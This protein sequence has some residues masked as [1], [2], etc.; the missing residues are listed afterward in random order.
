MTSI[1]LLMAAL[2]PL[3]RGE[4]FGDIRAGD[5]YVA[6]AKVQITCGAESAEGTTDKSGSFRL[7]V[8]ASG[9]CKFSVTHNKQTATIDVVLFDQPSRYRFVLEDAG[10]KPVLKRV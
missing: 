4:I 9:K 10:G 2:L 6:D 3:N 5:A 1:L 8:G 7:K